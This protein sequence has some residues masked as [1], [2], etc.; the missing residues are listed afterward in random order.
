MGKTVKQRTQ[1]TDGEG[2]HH[3]FNPGDDMPD[4]LVAR[5]D[6]PA[7][8]EDPEGEQ[9][10]GPDPFGTLNPTATV[11]G[12]GS[13]IPVGAVH[14]APYASEPPEEGVT[15]QAATGLENEQSPSSSET[16][17]SSSDED[18]RVGSVK[19]SPAELS[20]MSRADLSA[21]AERLGLSVPSGATKEQIRG[22]IDSAPEPAPGS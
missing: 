14:D 11:G 12:P 10:P 18:D 21:T 16:E 7:V 2:K 19:P 13:Q 22:L 6:N 8:W 1:V 3:I 9:V 15:N 17:G 4:E 5:V 20:G